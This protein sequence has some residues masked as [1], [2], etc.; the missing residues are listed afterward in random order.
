MKCALALILIGVTAFACSKS[1]PSASGKSEAKAAEMVGIDLSPGGAAW[2]GY[3]IKAPKGST[4]MEDR[5]NIRVAGMGCPVTET[6]PHFDLVLSQKKPNFTEMKSIQEEG[7]KTYK[8]KLQWIGETADTLEWTRETTD[9][10]NDKSLNF[11]RIVKVGDQELGC[12]PLTASSKESDIAA[13]KEA[14]TTL[15]KK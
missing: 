1:E 8:D 12:W 2:T 11:V 9:G 14:C 10:T 3:T 4:V 5:S 6:C 7:A 15:A 13:M